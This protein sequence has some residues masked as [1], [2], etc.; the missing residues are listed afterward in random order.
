MESTAEVLARRQVATIL[1][2]SGYNL[3]GPGHRCV[4]NPVIDELAADVAD[5]LARRPP[6]GEVLDAH[7]ELDLWGGL[8]HRWLTT[9][10]ETLMTVA[11]PRS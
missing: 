6:F 9:A 8:R 2:S 10:S 11:A 5:A 3:T 7:L 1:I 4:L